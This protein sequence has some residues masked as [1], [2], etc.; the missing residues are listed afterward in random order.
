[1]GV[2]TTWSGGGSTGGVASVT[3]A[4]AGIEVSPITGNVIL[5]LGELSFGTLWGADFSPTGST[6]LAEGEFPYYS[7]TAWV[8]GSLT[9]GTGIS[10]TPGATG[11]TLAVSGIPTSV[12]AA[13]GSV[14]VTPTTGAVTVKLGELNDGGTLDAIAFDVSSTAKGDLLYNNGSDWVNLGIGSAGQILEVSSGAPVWKSAIAATQL[15]AFFDG[16]VS[17]TT[18]YS[19]FG[20]NNAGGFGIDGANVLTVAGT[21]K[22]FYINIVSNTLS[23]SD[24]Y[25]VTITTYSAPGTAVSSAL[26]ITFSGGA[27][28]VESDTSHS[29]SVTAGQLVNITAKSG[30]GSGTLAFWATVEFDVAAA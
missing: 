11:I 10:V 27:T 15:M 26:T 8:I 24:S 9:A 4:N 21:L 29:I 2:L 17:T 19:A 20:G 23:G 28:G 3:S 1:M 5:T 16:T 12:T 22:N 7:G 13:N 6:T 18:Q 14:V 30:A 25:T